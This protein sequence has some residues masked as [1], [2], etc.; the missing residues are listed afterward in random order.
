VDE[1][2]ADKAF[3]P[4]MVLPG[5]NHGGPGR[6]GGGNELGGTRGLDF[7]TQRTAVQG[8]GPL[9]ARFLGAAVE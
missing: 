2:I 3:S 7:Y 1:K 9:L 8:N 6:A 4:G 5:L